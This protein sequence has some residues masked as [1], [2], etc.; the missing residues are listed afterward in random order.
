[1][2]GGL[3]WYPMLALL[4]VYPKTP[5]CTV[6][7]PDLT[8]RNE[9]FSHVGDETETKTSKTAAEKQRNAPGIA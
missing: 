1:M 4:P 8:S 5:K 9:I 2:L 3:K 7:D 6:V